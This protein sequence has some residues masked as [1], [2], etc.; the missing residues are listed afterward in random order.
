MTFFLKEIIFFVGKINNK[1]LV[2]GIII[3]IIIIYL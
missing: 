2:G 3:V 1:E